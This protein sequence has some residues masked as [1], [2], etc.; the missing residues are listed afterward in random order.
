MCSSE[1]SAGSQRDAHLKAIEVPL[2]GLGFI[3]RGAAR[4][5]HCTPQSSFPNIGHLG[6]GC[7][8]VK[9]CHLSFRKT[10]V[11]LGIGTDAFF[12]TG[13]ALL[14][15][16]SVLP[17]VSKA[18]IAAESDAQVNAAAAKIATRLRSNC[19][20]PAGNTISPTFPKLGGS[21]KFTS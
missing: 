12:I 10:R 14:L 1:A 15:G 21:S 2:Y 7:P 11:S 20:G 16:A 4:S 3:G 18:A 6:P 13:A 17:L 5:C 8:D 19:H 9:T